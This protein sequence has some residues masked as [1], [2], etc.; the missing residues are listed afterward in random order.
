M[1]FER[2]FVALL[3]AALVGGL[4]CDW[5]P[6][7]TLSW[8][9]TI[10]TWEPILNGQ[11]QL[12]GSY[13]FRT[14][15]SMPRFDLRSGISMRAENRDDQEL[16]P[17]NV[18][19]NYRLNGTLLYQAGFDLNKGK[20]RFSGSSGSAWNFAEDDVLDVELC[21]GGGNIPIHTMV[22]QSLS[23]RFQRSF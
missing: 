8:S 6:G 14:A 23:L 2:T 1:R 10:R 17:L 19:L 3:L 11:C 12:V 7:S 9:Q 18:D 5:Y 16:L 20:G 13:T 4:A 21:A 22:T 15:S